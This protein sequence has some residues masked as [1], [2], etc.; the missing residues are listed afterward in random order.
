MARRLFPAR[1]RAQLARQNEANLPDLCDILNKV[2]TRKPGGVTVFT[3]PVLQGGVRCHVSPASRSAAGQ[4]DVVGSQ[5]ADVGRWQVRL[6]KGV[7]V[8]LDG[9]LLATVVETG[10]TLLLNV[11]G[12]L[13]PRSEEATR[14]V[15]G[16]VVTD[17]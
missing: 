12:V 16:E 17:A 4:E 5:V 14:V 6:P 8:P 15:L 3:Y 2:P 13:G 11:L 10:D 9:R 1:T 7:S